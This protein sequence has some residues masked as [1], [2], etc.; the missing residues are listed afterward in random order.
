MSRSLKGGIAAQIL[1]SYNT[2]KLT[3]IRIQQRV[4][5]I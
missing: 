2:R 1:L 4:A 3:I 5:N